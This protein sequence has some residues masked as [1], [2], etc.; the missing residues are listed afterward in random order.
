[1]SKAKEDVKPI[2]KQKSPVDANKKAT[3]ANATK[4][5]K[6]LDKGNDNAPR[7][8]NTQ[9]KHRQ[10]NEHTI[11]KSVI[12]YI[13]ML[14]SLVLLLCMF[15]V[16]VLQLDTDGAGI[17]GYYLQW[18]FCGL[19]GAAAFIAP[20][21]LF[22]IGLKLCL[23][24]IKTKDISEDD[25]NEQNYLKLRS[26]TIL[27]I[28]MASVAIVLIAA[29]IGVFSEAFD[30]FELGD[31]WID[32]ADDLVGGGVIGGAIAVL[33][34]MAFERVISIII[35]IPLIT[36]AV[37]FAIGLT[38][39]KVIVY[40]KYKNML[41]RERKEEMRYQAELIER[42]RALDEQIRALL[43]EYHVGVN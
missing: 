42:E 9:K 21:V 17:V 23:Y 11:L 10:K 36:I 13:L 6:M 41:R 22:F 26:K 15:T 34:I 35:L 7:K 18:A 2:N 16:H 3:S 40:I 1:M 14:F 32:A 29:L 39:D 19:L 28:V 24:N 5:N 8:Q 27:Q 38:P 31:M 20:F 4:S 12:P 30:S 37:I 33:M 43:L 25:E